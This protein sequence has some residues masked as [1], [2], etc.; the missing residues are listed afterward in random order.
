MRPL[1]DDDEE[2]EEEEQVEVSKYWEAIVARDP[3]SRSP[4]VA[5]TV[6]VSYMVCLRRHPPRTK[7]KYINMKEGKMGE[8]GKMLG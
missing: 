2:D 6:P 1:L 4:S 7:I 8:G 3:S 5:Y